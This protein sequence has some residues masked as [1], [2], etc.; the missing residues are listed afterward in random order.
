MGNVEVVI[1]NGT[2]INYNDIDICAVTNSNIPFRVGSIQLKNSDPAVCQFSGAQKI[3]SF[4]RPQMPSLTVS[5]NLILS[6]FDMSFTCM[7]QLK[8]KKYTRSNARLGTPSPWWDFNNYLIN[9]PPNTCYP[10]TEGNYYTL[11][12]ENWICNASISLYT[13]IFLIFSLVLV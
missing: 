2:C 11:Y 12:R 10:V 5:A 8:N 7:I 1:E 3:N 9:V 6:N 13:S 4:T